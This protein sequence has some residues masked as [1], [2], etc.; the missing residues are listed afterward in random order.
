MIRL[1]LSLNFAVKQ[2]FPALEVIGWYSIGTKPT[3]DDSAMHRQV[4]VTV[5]CVDSNSF[6]NSSRIPSS[7]SSAPTCFPRLRDSL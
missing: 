5:D 6:L 1:R 7:F 2:V 4:S 3:D